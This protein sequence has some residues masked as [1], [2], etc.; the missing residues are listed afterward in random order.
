MKVTI[1]YCSMVEP[2]SFNCRVFTA[3]LS[4]ENIQGL[5]GTC[6][7]FRFS[8]NP[9]LHVKHDICMFFLILYGIRKA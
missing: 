8:Q 4:S 6:I 3:K 5:Y 9:Y 7:C 1:H 2:V